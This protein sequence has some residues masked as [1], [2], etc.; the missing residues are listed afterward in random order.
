MPVLKNQ[1]QRKLN[2]PGIPKGGVNYARAPAICPGTREYLRGGKAHIG[3][4]NDVEQLRPELQAL[5]PQHGKVLLQ[6]EIEIR[7]TGPDD[8]VSRQVP[9]GPRSRQ[10]E[11]MRI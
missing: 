11:S 8:R 4:I 7:K 10:S 5:L 2:L 1:L 6:G 3:M 9:E